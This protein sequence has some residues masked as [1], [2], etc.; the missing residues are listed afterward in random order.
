M[1]IETA[2]ALLPIQ[3]DLQPVAATHGQGIGTY[4]HHGRLR[5]GMRFVGFGK[6]GADTRYGS[7]GQI[8]RGRSVRGSLVDIYV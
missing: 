6:R 8:V 2:N 5:G 3:L 1:N 4:R 7:S